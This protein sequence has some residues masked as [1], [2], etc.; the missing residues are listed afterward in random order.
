MIMT[1]T[2]KQIAY[3][4]DL[5]AKAIQMIESYIGTNNARIGKADKTSAQ[6]AVVLPLV[7]AQTDAS[8][9]IERNNLLASHLL[10]QLVTPEIQ[11]KLRAI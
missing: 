6:L 8:W 10:K 9:W 1:G 11:A 3:A 2:P 4:E 5:K 7:E